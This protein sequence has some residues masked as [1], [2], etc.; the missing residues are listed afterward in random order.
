MKLTKT[1]FFWASWAKSL[2]HLMGKSLIK[3][4]KSSGNSPWFYFLSLPLAF[5][6]RKQEMNRNE[7]GWFLWSFRQFK[8]YIELLSDFLQWTLHLLGE[9]NVMVYYIP[10]ERSTQFIFWNATANIE[11]CFENKD[12]MS[13]E[14]LSMEYDIIQEVLTWG[15]NLRGSLLYLLSFSRKQLHAN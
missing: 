15:S 14:S 5:K 12:L 3:L 13:S 9:R 11:T 8:K 4:R 7:N 2:K 10:Q 1:G 6:E